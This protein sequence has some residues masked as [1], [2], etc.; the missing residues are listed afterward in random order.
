MTLCDSAPFGSDPGAKR[1]GCGVTVW[2]WRLPSRR[3][4]ESTGGGG[5]RAATHLSQNHSPEGMLE[6][7]GDAQYRWHLLSGF[8]L[9]L[10]HIA[11]QIFS[12]S[13]RLWPT[14]ILYLVLLKQEILTRN[15]F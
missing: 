7:A 9:G 12:G 11:G 10:I 14:R 6:S 2:I 3:E 15:E 1:C 4:G 5:A 8:G 13:K